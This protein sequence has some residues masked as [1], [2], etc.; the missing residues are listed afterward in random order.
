MKV[1]TD[2]VTN[3]SSSSFLIALK[4]NRLTKKQKDAIIDFMQLNA[5]GS[6]MSDQEIQED[7]WR[8]SDDNLEK[9]KQLHAKGWSINTGEVDREYDGYDLGCFLQDLWGYVEAADSDNIELLDTDLR[10]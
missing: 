8:F 5:F 4:N 1:R 7:K 2:F 10:Y 9:A 6:P 3:S